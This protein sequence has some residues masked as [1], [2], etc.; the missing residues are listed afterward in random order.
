MEKAEE[1]L[2]R[3]SR[4]PIV[5]V[6]GAGD[7]SADGALAEAVGSGVAQS[8]CTLLTGGG[9][10]AM[11]AASRGA[12][13]KGGLVVGVLPSSGPRDPAYR[14]EF[15]NPWVHVPI[16][17]G[18]S[19]GRNIINVKSADVVIALPGGPGTLSEIALA[20]KAKRPV[21]LVG[22]EDLKLPAGFSEALLHRAT[23][24]A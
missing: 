9:G 14:D 2:S 22:W 4:R 17:T 24:A 23:D 12:A 3:W 13:E 5:A 7:V 21:I 19:E 20:L 8:G 15:P 10:G 6:V 18:L 16:Y 11:A 1:G